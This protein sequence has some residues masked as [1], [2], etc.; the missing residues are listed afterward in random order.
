MA[1]GENIT[2]SEHYPLPNSDVAYVVLEEDV[3]I[4]DERVS[5]EVSIGPVP[6]GLEEHVLAARGL[7]RAAHERATKQPEM[8]R[9]EDGR[10]VE[11]VIYFDSPEHE[12]LTRSIVKGRALRYNQ[13]NWLKNAS[14]EAAGGQRGPNVEF[15]ALV[16]PKT[17][18]PLASV[19]LLHG[20]KL[21]DM[22]SYVKA[23]EAGAI[24]EE[25][26]AILDE[27]TPGRPIAEVCDLWGRKSDKPEEEC[28]PDAIFELYRR[29]AKMSA[30][31]EENLFCGAVG[32][33]TRGVMRYFG[34]HVVRIVGDE[35]NTG[36]P[37]AKKDVALTPILMRPYT[38]VRDLL[39]WADEA[40]LAARE[41]LRAGQVAEWKKQHELSL[42]RQTRVWDLFEV[43]PAKCIDPVTRGR[44]RKLGYGNAA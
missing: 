28:P 18:K 43:M 36:D 26:Q 6:S 13:A 29:I 2:T 8:L 40:A 39:D 32:P 31:R 5:H 41:F 38:I 25:G 35:F 21:T 3:F 19:R 1:T 12:E 10:E 27:I 15:I 34:P 44:I 30:E 7:S 4:D 42:A 37:T 23:V 17:R 24:S 20:S 33:E 22:P 16:D 11:W 9:L 14:P